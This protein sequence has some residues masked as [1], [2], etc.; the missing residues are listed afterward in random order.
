[1]PSKKIPSE[2]LTSTEA[3]EVSSTPENSTDADTDEDISL[4]LSLEINKE[5]ETV[6]IPLVLPELQVYIVYKCAL[7]KRHN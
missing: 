1:M 6:K 2:Y 4:Q 5:E 3:M 7:Y